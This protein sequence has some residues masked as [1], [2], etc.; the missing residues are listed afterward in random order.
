MSQ[1]LEPQDALTRQPYFLDWLKQHGVE[2]KHTYR[3]KVGRWLMKVWQYDRDL[4]GRKFVIGG[5]VA[6]RLPFW[7]RLN[8]PLPEENR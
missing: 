3:I 5:D 4:A 6:R 1:V 8:A 7:K 2:P